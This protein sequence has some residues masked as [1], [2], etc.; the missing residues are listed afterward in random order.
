MGERTEPGTR[1]A[2]ASANHPPD[3][4]TGQP[5]RQRHPSST[6][7]DN[8][9]IDPPARGEGFSFELC[10][11]PVEGDELVLDGVHGGSEGVPGCVS[12]LYRPVDG[13]LCGVFDGLDDVVVDPVPGGW[14]T[15][16]LTAEA[17]E[18]AQPKPLQQWPVGSVP[19]I[20]LSPT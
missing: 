20:G 5:D 7:L 17:A 3:S 8:Y 13:V 16:R 6:S 19:V 18:Q 9:S 2:P 10:N 11:L 14:M 4:I 15:S 1:L 12:R